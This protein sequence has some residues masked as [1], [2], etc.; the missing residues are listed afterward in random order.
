MKS[1]VIFLVVISSFS[2]FGFIGNKEIGFKV[3]CIDVE[4]NAEKSAE[5]LN[6]ALNGF[7]KILDVSTPTSINGHPFRAVK[8]SDGSYKYVQE[9]PAQLCVTVKYEFEYK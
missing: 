9:K 1:L 5:D 8:M 2:A 3:K 7:S 6:D 4:S